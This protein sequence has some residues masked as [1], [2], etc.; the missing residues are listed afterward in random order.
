MSQ[1]HSMENILSLTTMP[2]MAARTSAPAV[3]AAELTPK[4]NFGVYDPDNIA[5]VWSPAGDRELARY[6]PGEQYVDCVELSVLEFAGSYG[7]V[8]PADNS[9]LKALIYFK[10]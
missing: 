9:L 8:L 2:L 4:I 6:W 5:Y 10:A 7:G 1:K 3:G